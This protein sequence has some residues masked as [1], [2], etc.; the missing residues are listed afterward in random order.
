MKQNKCK[1]ISIIVV[2]GAHSRKHT[3][4]PIHNVA[5]SFLFVS[6]CFFFLFLK[7]SKRIHIVKV[8]SWIKLPFVNSGVI[9]IINYS[10]VALKHI[11]SIHFK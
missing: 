4:L 11:L 6:L 5:V 2:V 3:S 10:G 1:V 9:C 8:N 7:G